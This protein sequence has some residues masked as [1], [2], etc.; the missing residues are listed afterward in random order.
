MTTA[1]PA[2][3]TYLPDDA[4]DSLSALRRFLADHAGEPPGA[5]AP[6]V[7]LV[8]DTG[9]V[10]L[11]AQVHQVLQHVVAALAAGRA[12]TVAP[13]SMLLTTQ[14]TADLLGVSRPTIVR[15]ID[16]GDLPA[17]RVGN[18]RRVRLSDA[19]AYRDRRRRA[20]YDMLAAT[21]VDLD[22]EDDPATVRER[23]RTARQAAT[24]Q[25]RGR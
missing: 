11:P 19:L 7:H 4:P 2:P 22:D 21:A 25:R 13:Q 23:L 1:T 12:V 15:V 6:R 9:R 10:E 3:E 5:G 24:T 20:Q 16:A 18:R 8:G 14:Q 17:E